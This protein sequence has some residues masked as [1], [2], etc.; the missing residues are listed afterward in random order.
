MA[1]PSACGPLKGR[2]PSACLGWPL[3]RAVGTRERTVCP[4]PQVACPVLPVCV[5]PRGLARASRHRWGSPH[6]GRVDV[7]AER[8]GDRGAGSFSSGLVFRS[9]GVPVCPHPGARPAAVQA[10]L[11]AGRTALQRGGRGEGLP[12]PG[13][14]GHR[15]TYPETQT[16]PDVRHCRPTSA[17]SCRRVC[18]RVTACAR[19]RGG[20]RAPAGPSLPAAPVPQPRARHAPGAEPASLRGP[21]GR[22]GRPPCAVALSFVRSVPC[23]PLRLGGARAAVLGSG[24]R[25]EWPRGLLPGKPRPHPSRVPR[26]GVRQLFSV[27]RCR[28]VSPAR[29]DGPATPFTLCLR[30][31]V[32]PADGRAGPPRPGPGILSALSLRTLTPALT[33]FLAEHSLRALRW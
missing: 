4:A 26:A 27:E 13:G 15:L 31:P 3:S 23:Q 25:A 6:L 11:Q 28:A 2:G 20:V 24:L 8:L 9:H 17:L 33:P 30:R 19:A 14:P 29:A 18:A 16:R 12:R 10:D 22:R 32:S 1:H 7:H 21:M 5:V